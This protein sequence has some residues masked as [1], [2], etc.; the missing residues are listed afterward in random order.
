MDKK[1]I[2]NLLNW[3]ALLYMFGSTCFLAYIVILIV[4]NGGANFY[5]AFGL[6]EGI[7]ELVLFALLSPFA[8]WGLYRYWKH[9][10]RS[11]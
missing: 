8:L 11:K 5:F 10:V 6:A 7:L 2:L 1:L 3:G 9:F 4:K